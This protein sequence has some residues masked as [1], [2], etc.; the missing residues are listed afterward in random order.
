MNM[1]WNKSNT[2]LIIA[3]IIINI[4]LLA[5]T[6]NNIYK[7][8]YNVLS[9]KDFINETEQILKQKNITINCSIPKETYILP[10]LET[11]YEIIDVNNDLIQNYL[12]K[13][14]E[15][16]EDVFSYSNEKGETLDIIDNKKIVFKKRNSL[17]GLKPT[18]ENI[19]AYIESFAKEKNLDMTK[20]DRTYK[21]DNDEGSCI[22]YNMHQNNISIDNSYMRFFIDNEGIYMFEMQRIKSTMEIKEKIRTVSSMEALLRLMTYDNLKDKEIDG[23]EMVYYSLEDNNWKYIIKTNSDPTWKVIFKD[24]NQ[25]HLPSS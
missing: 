23:I 16:K 20:Y 11:E 3:F 7:D 2:I 12:G 5:T 25:L 24:G 9:D 13:G 8:E 15:A 18:E 21:Y 1:D 17:K 14:V 4:L 22:I 10:V 6:I 19:L